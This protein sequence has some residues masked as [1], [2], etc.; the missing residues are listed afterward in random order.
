MNAHTLAQ[1]AYAQSASSTR[2]LR[3]T[4]Y[5]IIARVSYRLKAAAEAKPADFPALAAALNDN[6]KLWDALAIDVAN[7][8]NQLPQ[9][10]RA[11]IFSLAQFVNAHT[12]KAIARKA[13]VGPLLEINAAILKGLSAK[14]AER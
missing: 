2:T 14:R 8:E 7:P 12:S 10:L 5:R 6:R 1:N 9:A 3:D 13:Q 4:E 11:Q